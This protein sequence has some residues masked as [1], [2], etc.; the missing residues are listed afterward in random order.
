MQER[1]A[2]LQQFG[3]RG[4]G[5]ERSAAESDATQKRERQPSPT[6]SGAS[7]RSMAPSAFLHQEDAA[8]DGRSDYTNRREGP[9]TEFV[10]A[11]DFQRAIADFKSE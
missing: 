5:S 8:W 11:E 10:S 9:Q 3:H 2:K 4:P 7:S 1:F 6:A